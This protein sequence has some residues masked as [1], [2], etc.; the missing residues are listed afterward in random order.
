MFKIFK[1]IKGKAL[2]FAILGI[3]FMLLGCAC[4]IL[5]PYLLQNIVDCVAK[6]QDGDTAKYTMF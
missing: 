3:V 5:Q 6:I 1:F 4:D 2:L